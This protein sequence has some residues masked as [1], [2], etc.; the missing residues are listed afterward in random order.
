MLVDIQ[1]IQDIQDKQLVLDKQEFGFLKH[2]LLNQ[3]DLDMVVSHFLIHNSLN[4]GKV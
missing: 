2:I 4:L 1:D 3:E